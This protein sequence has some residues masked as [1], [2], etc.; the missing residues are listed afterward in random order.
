MAS[1]TPTL[2]SRLKSLPEDY[3]PYLFF[4]E[5]ETIEGMSSMIQKC[6]DLEPSFLKNF[7]REASSFILKNKTSTKQAKRIVDSLIELS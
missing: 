2:M 1:G 3:Y 4:F 7:G 5:N 6:L